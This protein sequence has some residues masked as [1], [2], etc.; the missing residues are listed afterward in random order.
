MSCVL[1]FVYMHHMCAEA[2]GS[3]NRA[4]SPLELELQGAVNCLVCA[5][6]QTC[7]LYMEVKGQPA[8]SSFLLPSRA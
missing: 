5:G 6:S 2:R 3:Q 8:V 7:S 4:S 1:E